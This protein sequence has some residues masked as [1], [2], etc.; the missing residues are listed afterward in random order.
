MVPLFFNELSAL[1]LCTSLDEARTRLGSYADLLLSIKAHIPNIEVRY[2]YSLFYT[3]ILNGSYIG[4]VCLALVKEARKNSQSDDVNRFQYLLMSQHDPYIKE[5]LDDSDQI[6][7]VLT[8]TFL[9]K[10]DNELI[11]V[12]GFKAAYFCNSIC[13][14]LFSE[15][16]WRNHIHTIIIDN[17]SEPFNID[18]ACISKEEHLTTQAYTEW[19]DRNVDVE[20]KESTIPI[21]KKLGQNHKAVGKHHGKELLYAHALKLIRSPYI[22]EIITSAAYGTPSDQDYIAGYEDTVGVIRI[23]LIWEE[24][25]VSMIVRTTGRNMKETIAIANILR[26]QFAK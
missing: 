26:S 7:Y 22:D 4:N 17:G 20:L 9:K 11:P 24:P 14:G 15:P 3:E 25:K 12:E 23:M 8:K 13:V 16:Y 10:N 5:E 6:N 19:V 1:P 2:Q 21:A 18:I